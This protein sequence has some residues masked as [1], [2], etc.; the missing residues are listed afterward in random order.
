MVLKYL[1]VGVISAILV[2]LAI[3]LMLDDETVERIR[4]D[5]DQAVMQK[6]APELRRSGVPGKDARSDSPETQRIEVDAIEI[7]GA[8]DAAILDDLNGALADDDHDK[9]AD[10]IRRLSSPP[11]RD[12]ARQRIG[13]GHARAGRM[14]DALAMAEAV[15]IAELADPVRAAI[16]RAAE[17]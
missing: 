15:E 13:I 11:L 17:E 9:A 7:M 8:R 10:L 16:L 12:T 2:A 4:A 1:T 5:R 3:F 6:A 14:D